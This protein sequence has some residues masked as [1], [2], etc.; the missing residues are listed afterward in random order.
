M[1]RTGANNNNLVRILTWAPQP[2]LTTCAIGAPPIAQVSNQ[3][4]FIRAFTGSFTFSNFSITTF[5]SFPP[6]LS[7]LRM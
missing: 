6:T 3:P 7:T 4:Y 2:N 1:C 5:W